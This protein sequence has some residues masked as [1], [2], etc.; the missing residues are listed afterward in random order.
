MCNG[1][2]ERGS[3]QSFWTPVIGGDAIQVEVYAGTRPA[4]LSFDID[5]LVF[6]RLEGVKYSIP[7]GV[8]NREDVYLMPAPVQQSARAV[9]KLQFVSDG[10]PNAC[11]G[12]LIGPARFATETIIASRTKRRVR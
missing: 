2:V 7:G 6:Q 1:G 12:F 8:D 10:V 5:K 9:G 4:G 3:V 11:T